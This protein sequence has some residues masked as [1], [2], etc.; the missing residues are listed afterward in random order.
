MDFRNGNACRLINW[1]MIYACAD[2]R[3]R[4]GF[5]ALFWLIKLSKGSEN[6]SEGQFHKNLR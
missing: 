4:N 3:E 2:G 1:E 5:A 6:P